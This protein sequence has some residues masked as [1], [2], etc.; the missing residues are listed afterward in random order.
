MGNLVEVKGEILDTAIAEIK[1]AYMIWDEPPAEAV[2]RA[3][4]NVASRVL[5]ENINNVAPDTT[6]HDAY[7]IASNLLKN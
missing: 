7:R 2:A 5:M 4:L 3:V 6:A 1:H